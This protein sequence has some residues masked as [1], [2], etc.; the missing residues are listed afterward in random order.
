[1]TFSN[2]VS[3][4]KAQNSNVSFATF[5]W[6]ETLELRA[7]SF[8][9]AFENVTPRGIGCTILLLCFILFIGSLI[10]F[11]FTADLLGIHKK[12]LEAYLYVEA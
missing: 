1:M 3:R 9:I 7:L 6:K 2:A 5:Q 4:L 11:G 12:C 8:E 10:Y